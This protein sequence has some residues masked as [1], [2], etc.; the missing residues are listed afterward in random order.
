MNTPVYTHED[1]DAFE[2]K[3]HDR[4]PKLFAE[5]YGG[6]AI[7]PG[8]WRMIET[9]CF[10]I[11][12]HIDW[13]QHARESLLAN[14]PYN[15]DIPDHVDQVVVTQI[16]EKFGTL[17]FYYDGGDDVVRGLVDMAES[18]S[19]HLCEECGSPGHTRSGGW[20]RTLCDKHEAERQEKMKERYA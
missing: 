6:F 1:Y 7:G 2:K 10:N 16:K 20:M 17:R 15:L 4:F 14:N 5:P 19:A 11:Q 18:M 8:W 13:K 12:R 9:L 3:M